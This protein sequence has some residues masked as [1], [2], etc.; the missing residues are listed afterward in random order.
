MELNLLSEP[1][2]GDDRGAGVR[3]DPLRE[4]MTEIII[5]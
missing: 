4:A 2:Q 5:V 3:T 1:L